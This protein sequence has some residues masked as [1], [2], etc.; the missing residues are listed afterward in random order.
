[1]SIFANPAS[2]ILSLSQSMMYLPSIALFL[3]GTISEMGEE[4]R[5]I[6]PTC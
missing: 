1:M 5:I 4:L 2:A 3:K 6:P